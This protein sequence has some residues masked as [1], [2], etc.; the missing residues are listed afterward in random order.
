MK[1]E[2]RL[3]E[4]I[5]D[6]TKIFYTILTDEPY[7]ETD[8]YWIGGDITGVCGI[9]DYF[10]DLSDMVL[11]VDNNVSGED[12]IN[13]YWKFCGEYEKGTK[14]YINLRSYL[15]NKGYKLK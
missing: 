2:H 10:V 11:V 8:A 12:Y 15:M 13:W 5:T 4:V 6:Y 3:K 1:L 14:Q 9:G 7:D